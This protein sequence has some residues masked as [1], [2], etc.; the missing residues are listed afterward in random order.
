[1]IDMKTISDEISKLESSRAS[2]PTCQK[3]AD[4]YIVK[5]HLMKKQGG[6]DYNYNRNNYGY[7]ERGGNSG[8]T[9]GSS[10]YSMYENYNMMMDDEMGMGM[11]RPPRMSTPSMR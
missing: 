1:M 2:Y 6:G 10:N 5:D 11:E 9:G 7:Y 3:L 8:N 4:L